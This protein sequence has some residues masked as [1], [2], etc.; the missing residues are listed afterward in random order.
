MGVKVELSLVKELVFIL[1]CLF[2]I[3]AEYEL[4][5]FGATSDEIR[6]IAFYLNP[7]FIDV[8]LKTWVSTSDEIG[9]ITKD[10]YLNCTE[11]EQQT[12][13]SSTDWSRAITHLS[14]TKKAWKNF[15]QCNENCILAFDI[16]LICSDYR[17]KHNFHIIMKFG[18][19]HATYNLSVQYLSS[20]HDSR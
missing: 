2:L 6:S 20:K 5:T 16:L 10:L 9:I 4:E 3:R 14:A 7:H 1:L 13:L 12:C 18:C 8:S 17:C 19:L 11:N 15:T